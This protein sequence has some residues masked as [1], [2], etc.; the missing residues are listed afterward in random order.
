MRFAPLSMRHGPIEQIISLAYNNYNQA[1]LYDGYNRTARNFSKENAYYLN[2]S[3]AYTINDL[4]SGELKF[5]GRYRGNTKFRDSTESIAPYYNIPIP[6]YTRLPDGTIV[7]KDYSG[8]RFFNIPTSGGRTPVTYFLDPNLLSR[9]IYGLYNLNPLINKDA[10]IQWHDLNINGYANSDGTGPEYS[11]NIALSAGNYDIR[12]RVTAGYLMNTLNMGNELTVITGL[13]V[14]SENN[15]YNSKWSP[16]SLAGFPSPSGDIRD[17]ASSHKETIWLP[18]LQCL[19]KPFDFLNIR[20]VGYRSISRPDFNKRLANYIIQAAGTF[21]PTNN[22][23]IG[24]PSLRDAKAYNYEINTSVYNNYIGLFSVSGYYK[25]ITDMYHT[26]S[27]LQVYYQDGQRILDSLGLHVVN[28]FGNGYFQITYQ[29][30]SPKPTRI[31]GVEVEHQINF[32]F[33][34]SVL[35]NFVLSYNFSFIHTETYIPTNTYVNYYIQIGPVRIPKVKPI[36][37][38]VKQKL[39]NSPDFLLNVSLGYDFA[40]FSARISVFHQSKTNSFFSYD[41]RQDYQINAITRWDIA[42]KQKI[43]D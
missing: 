21:Y 29:S 32:W 38:D 8:T 41:A 10:L 20:L 17:T 12:E 34:P 37:V 16:N 7:P 19:Y 39:E 26:I 18:N 5:G 13:R 1:T 43:N 23:T 2:I 24:N 27:G 11:E 9:N 6:G 4:F 15:S 14:E 42:L 31:W 36:I 3:K 35:S 40:D 22:L 33:L 30:N 25:E 28:P